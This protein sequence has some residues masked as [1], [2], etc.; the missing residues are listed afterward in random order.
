MKQ[1]TEEMGVHKAWYE[2]AR[3]QTMESLPDFLKKLTT[4]YQH[5]YGTVCHAVAAAGVGAMWAV[6]RAPNVGGGI[7][8]FQA[9]AI[10]WEV[11]SAWGVFGSG[12]KRMVEYEH[13]LYPAYES[14]FRAISKETWD[15]LQKKAK[16]NLKESNEHTHPRVLAHWENIANGDVPFGYLVG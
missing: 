4:E 16:A 9:G 3:K 11:I 2:E 14:D 1:I 15:W 12:P 5:D 8:G 6:E 7:T 10:M 13:M